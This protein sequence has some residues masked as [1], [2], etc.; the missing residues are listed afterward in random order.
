M[1][2][3]PSFRCAAAA[4]TVK[5]TAVKFVRMISSKAA[6]DVWPTGVVPYRGRNGALGSLDVRHISLDGQHAFT[7]FCRCCAQR[8]LV[9]SGYGNARTLR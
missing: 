8:L 3:A 7:K 1:I 5:N 9:T 2:D 4:C 6:S